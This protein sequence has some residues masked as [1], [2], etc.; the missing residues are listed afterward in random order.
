MN[1]DD[2]AQRGEADGAEDD[3]LRPVVEVERRGV[4]EHRQRR[5][6]NDREDL[7]VALL[8]AN[9]LRVRKLV[10]RGAKVVPLVLLG[11]DA[12]TI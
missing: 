6:Q 3:P 10:G 12:P 9:L 5:Q 8:A 2:R 4:G 7:Q 11:G 1:G